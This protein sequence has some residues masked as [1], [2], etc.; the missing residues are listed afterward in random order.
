MLNVTVQQHMEF[1]PTEWARYWKA[2]Y[3]VDSQK[4]SIQALIPIVGHD[5]VTMLGLCN[6]I[7][8][9][10]PQEDVT[11][12][13]K[14]IIPIFGADNMVGRMARFKLVQQMEKE[15][16]TD[17]AISELERLIR[18]TDANDTAYDNYCVEMGALLKNKTEYAN[19]ETWFQKTIDHLG[20]KESANAGFGT[21]LL[22]HG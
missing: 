5:F 6:M 14:K 10:L 12:F 9:Y 13:T 17:E 22:S 1:H 21:C 11:P 15:G 2:L 16:K 20:P 8:G 19:A 18:E 4:Y 7:T 3:Q